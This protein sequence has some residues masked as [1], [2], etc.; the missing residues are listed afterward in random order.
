MMVGRG[1]R[2]ALLL[3]VIKSIRSLSLCSC[4]CCVN[5]EGHSRIRLRVPYCLLNN[6]AR[7]FGNCGCVF[8]AKELIVH[9]FL[10]V[11]FFVNLADE[12]LILSPAHKANG[13]PN[14]ALLIPALPCRFP[15]RTQR[16]L[17]QCRPHDYD[18]RDRRV[19]Q[20]VLPLRTV[21]GSFG[22][23]QRT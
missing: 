9:C 16:R 5:F 6:L 2:M 8:S 22:W 10:P 18:S 11:S 3:V 14:S 19:P 1:L 15:K 20:E 13:V 23:D 12:G 21:F 4:H 7:L 17:C